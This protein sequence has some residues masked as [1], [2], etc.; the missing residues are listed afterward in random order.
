MNPP[1]LAAPAPRTGR[2]AGVLT[3]TLPVMGIP[4]RFETDSARVMEGVD[5]AFGAWAGVDAAGWQGAPLTVRIRLTPGSEGADGRVRLRERWAGGRLRV[6]TPGSRGVADIERRTAVARVTRALVRDREQLRHGLLERLTLW[7]VTAMDRQPLHAAA[8]ERDGVALVLA[9]RSG[10][11]KSTLVYA[12][13]RAGFRV[14]TEDCVFLESRPETRVW[15]MPG[16]VHLLPEAVRWFP[17]L[18]GRT[19]TP[20]ANGKSKIAVDLR[21][22]CAAAPA[23]PVRRAGICLLA[24]GPLPCLEMLPP[25]AIVGALTTQLEPGFHRFAS[26]LGAPVRRL[27]E[28]GG[29]RLTLPECPHDA[30]PLLHTLFDAL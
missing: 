24:R 7:M 25:H 26:T 2:R 28:R 30:A 3:R 15:G 11:G 22:A 18:E 27:A 14:L 6:R 19:P 8:L 16:S 13:M 1:P 20:R 29:W 23:L 12:A 10:V 5:E 21:E 4:V 9:G 17:E